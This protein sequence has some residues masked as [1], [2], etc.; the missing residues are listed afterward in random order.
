MNARSI[1]EN[2]I[3]TFSSVWKERI[4]GIYIL[5][6]GNFAKREK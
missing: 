2:Q 1:Y 6:N 5:K 4:A 3:E